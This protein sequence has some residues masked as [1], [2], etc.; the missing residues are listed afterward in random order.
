MRRE[1]KQEEEMALTSWVMDSEG[2]KMNP[3]L[4]AWTVGFGAVQRVADHQESS[5]AEGVGLGGV[6]GERE[7]Q[8]GIVGVGDD[9]E[10]VGSGDVSERGHVDI[11]EGRAEG[12]TLGYA[13][14]DFGDL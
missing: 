13:A 9:V 4:R 8:L 3:M 6:L 2:S 11:E 1:L 14:D 7:D 10:V 12:R 5:H